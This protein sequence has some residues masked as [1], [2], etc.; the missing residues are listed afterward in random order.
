MLYFPYPPST[1]FVVISS[2]LF[3]P[4]L[5]VMRGQEKIRFFCTSSTHPHKNTLPPNPFPQAS[6]ELRTVEGEKGRG[7]SLRFQT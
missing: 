7:K 1:A 3:V 5:D 2:H 6:R 4:P